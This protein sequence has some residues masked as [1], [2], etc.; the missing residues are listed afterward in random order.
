MFGAPES[1]FPSATCRKVDPPPDENPVE[2]DL[3]PHNER[4][5]PSEN[6]HARS[7]PMAR[8]C[9]LTNPHER[10]ASPDRRVLLADTDPD[11]AS[12]RPSAAEPCAT[13]KRCSSRCEG[14][15]RSRDR[16]VDLHGRDWKFHTG[17][18]GRF[19]RSGAIRLD[20]HRAHVRFRHPVRQK[21][22]TASATSQS[23]AS[24]PPADRSAT[25]AIAS[26]SA[27]WTTPLAT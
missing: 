20:N 25:N 27:S 2:H 19:R 1:R 6:P 16:C 9:C 4:P 7:R 5:D 13:W 11:P 3:K 22:A 17:L 8:N 24:A 14:D 15:I 26:G 10:A 18:L 12:D 21:P 23:P